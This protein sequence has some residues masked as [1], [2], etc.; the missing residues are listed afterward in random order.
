[1]LPALP[2][3]QSF[4]GSDWLA[5][6]VCTFTP[7]TSVIAW[8]DSALSAMHVCTHARSQ[9]KQPRP[10]FPPDSP[11]GARGL[12]SL[13]R[14]D[15]QKRI[16]RQRG[17]AGQSG[18]ETEG[19]G[20]PVRGAAPVAGIRHRAAVVEMQT[21]LSEK[22]QDRRLSWNVLNRN[23]QEPGVSTASTERSGPARS[24]VSLLGDCTAPRGSNYL[25]ACGKG[26]CMQISS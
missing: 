15:S 9:L 22:N 13:M 8:E 3:L 11:M 24:L 14:W 10:T 19:A 12:N 7:C 6:Q 2:Q 17:T 20:K 1:M 16:A 4:Q 23:G 18:P 26:L 21:K 5:T 25:Q